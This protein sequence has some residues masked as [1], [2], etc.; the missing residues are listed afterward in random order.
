M[1]NLP[2]LG[3]VMLA[4]AAFAATP[5][6]ASAA[7]PVFVQTD[8]LA[9]N[10]VVAYDRGS[11]GQLTQA[12]SY[13][14]GGN[15]GQQA[16]SV[17]DHLA[18]QGSL[19]YDR[20]DGLLLA[21]NAGSN[22]VAVFGVYGDR[23]ALR[24]DI[25]SGGAFPS[26]I[27][28][29]GGRVYVL[30]AAGGGTVQGFEVRAGRLSPIAGASLKLELPQEEPQFV[31]T[32]GQIALTPD[33]SR[34][35]VTTKAATNAVELIP[36]GPGGTLGAPVSNALPGKVPFALAFDR[37]GHL[38]VGEA[39]GFLATFQVRESGVIDQ[40]DA[41]PTSQAA[42]CWVTAVGDR[43]YASNTGSSTLTSFRASEGGELLTNLGNTETD[44]APVDSAAT[45]GGRYLYVQ[46]GA[47]GKV[48]EF[49]VGAHDSLTKVGSV[50]VP[51][52]VGGEGIV[53]G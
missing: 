34:L 9:G 27:T 11:E 13:A 3:A 49:A 4:A 7:T 46:T 47:E 23:L 20:Q 33:G 51:G 30:N 19:A 36:V 44:G 31:H 32:P 35:A 28:V 43:L 1:H 50:T 52:A 18:S 29:G 42:T 14:T 5:A 22:T 45:P 2:R 37:R 48:D 26:S 10:H 24:Q 21:V 17:V 41:V 12:G 6:L 38:V 15:G 39:A 40:L 25:A 16:G 8:A 53:A